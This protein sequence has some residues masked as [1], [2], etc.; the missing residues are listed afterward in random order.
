[1]QSIGSFGRLNA[2]GNSETDRLQYVIIDMQASLDSAFARAGTAESNTIAAENRCVELLAQ[3]SCLTQARDG[4]NVRMQDY[5]ATAAKCQEEL[6]E[7]ENVLQA[8]QS[9]L[10]VALIAA[11]DREAES[12]RNT[13]E[14]TVIRQELQSAQQKE[15]ELFAVVKRLEAAKAS[16]DA[17]SNDNI[18]QLSE[19]LRSLQLALQQSQES[20]SSA[21]ERKE[22][23]LAMEIADHE[24]R[25]D[26]IMEE[27]RTDRLRV[28]ASAEGRILE[29][30]RLCDEKIDSFKYDTIYKWGHFVHYIFPGT[31]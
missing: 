12:N 5:A 8:V 13:E 4:L 9:Q 23:Q 21:L 6:L 25:I 31:R 2:A 10:S 19:E 17:S 27:H 11:A 3:C 15:A 1:V 14:L 28:L 24:S 29:A 7:K 20:F 26:G 18:V 16:S 30:R 22:Q